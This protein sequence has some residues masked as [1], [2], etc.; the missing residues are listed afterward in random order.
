[1]IQNKRSRP[2]INPS[3]FDITFVI[4]VIIVIVIIISV[5]SDSKDKLE[6]INKFNIVVCLI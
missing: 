2:L 5:F 1:M 6:L 3:E 4:V